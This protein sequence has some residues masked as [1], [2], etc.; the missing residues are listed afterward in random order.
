MNRQLLRVCLILSVLVPCSAVAQQP[1]GPMH[2]IT[3]YEITLLGGYRDGGSLQGFETGPL[4][5]FAASVRASTSLAFAVDV[6]VSAAFQVEL[7]GS[8]QNGEVETG[9]PIDG[10]HTGTDLKISYLQLGVVKNW[11][12]SDSVAYYLTVATGVAQLRLQSLTR[13]SE[14]RLSA[15][16]A[17]GV[18]LF[19]G[20]YSAIR[21][22]LRGYWIG[23]DTRST[24]I[25]PGALIYFKKN[26]L[27]AEASVGV[28]FVW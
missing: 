9:I 5:P 10:S 13:R 18:K 4:K 8:R 12:S 24:A 20:D 1:G 22:D 25:A 19:L 3:R 16:L 14:S 26:F 27:Q 15:S 6:P 28:S 23:T 7:W 2:S 11:Y 17:G 21:L